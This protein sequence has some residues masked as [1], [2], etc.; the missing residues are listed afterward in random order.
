MEYYKLCKFYENRATD[1]ALKGASIPHFD[2]I[3]VKKIQFWGSYTLTVALIVMEEG[4]FGPLIHATFHHNRCNVSPLRDE[5]P[6]NRSLSNLNT[7]R[8]RFAQCC[9]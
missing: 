2:Q 6:Q 1:T 8:L 5:K 3:S 4:T 9:R 7:D